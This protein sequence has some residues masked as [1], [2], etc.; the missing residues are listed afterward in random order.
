METGD[1]V[2]TLHGLH[3]SCLYA[4]QTR[5]L[6]S[7]AAPQRLSEVKQKTLEDRLLTSVDRKKAV[8]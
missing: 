7:T 6:T 8:R 4:P 5:T 2:I 3:T 1:V